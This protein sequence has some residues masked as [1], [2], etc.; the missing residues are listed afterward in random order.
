MSVTRYDL[1]QEV[2]ELIKDL[3]Y[4]GEEEWAKALRDAIRKGSTST[5]IMMLIRGQLKLLRRT[6]TPERLQLGERIDEALRYI[7]TVLAP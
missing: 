7:D 3:T 4:G 2:K 1:Y 6:D 5:E